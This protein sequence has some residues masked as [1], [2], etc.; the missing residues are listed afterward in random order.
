VVGGDGRWQMRLY[1]LPDRDYLYD[2]AYERQ[3][4]ELVMASANAG[5]VA[6]TQDS[7]TATF[8]NS[9]ALQY[10]QTGMVF[11][12]GTITDDPGSVESVTPYVWE[13]IVVAKPT[14]T[15]LTLDRVATATVTN[16]K[17][18]VSDLLDVEPTAMYAA[19]V[20]TAEADLAN[21]LSVE[22]DVVQQ[23]KMLAQQRMMVAYE[24]DN[25]TPPVM[26]PANYRRIRI[27][28]EKVIRDA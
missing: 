28:N 26:L 16:T 22:R 17:Y 3:A 14:A 19:L 10:V 4:R 24:L 18:L 20:A 8:S 23:K 12:L 25:R 21:L 9:S 13:A 1:P 5:T 7:P 11:R 27:F 6:L 2:Y 15:T